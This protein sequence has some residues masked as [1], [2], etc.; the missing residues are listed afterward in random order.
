M[1]HAVPSEQIELLV[2]M[3]CP[4]LSFHCHPLTADDPRVVGGSAS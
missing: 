1:T 4:H 2:R 3:H